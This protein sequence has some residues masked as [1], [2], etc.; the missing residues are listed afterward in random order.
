M[1]AGGSTREFF[2]QQPPCPARL[3]A[4]AVQ[5]AIY[6]APAERLVAGKSA[7]H[8]LHC[9]TKMWATDATPS[10]SGGIVTR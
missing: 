3:W 2:V 8:Y 7:C 9:I 6:I 10:A 1:D 5:P 4:P